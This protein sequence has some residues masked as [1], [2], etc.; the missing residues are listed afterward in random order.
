MSTPS[1][2]IAPSCFTPGMSA[3]RRLIERRKVDFP[4][5][6]GPM[7]DVTCLAGMASEMSSRACLAPYQK[8]KWR[9]SIEPTDAT[10]AADAVLGLLGDATVFETDADAA[11]TRSDP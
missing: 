10:S 1:S 5:P 11:L 9:A 3:L 8:L 4:H 2:R 6:D 7:S